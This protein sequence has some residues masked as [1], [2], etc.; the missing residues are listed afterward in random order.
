MGKFS[1]TTAIAYTNAPPHVGFALEL[2]QA[3]VLA[4]WH[5]LRGEKCFFLTGTDE[6]G[7]KVM[8]AAA[9]AGEDLQTFVDRLA[10]RFK[11]LASAL[12]ISND[13]FI[14]TSDRNRHWPGVRKLWK[15]LEEAGDLSRGT[16]RGLYCEGCEAFKKPSDLRDGRCPDHQTVPEVIEEENW[17]FR[18]SRYRD[19][20]RRIIESDEIRIV[21][22]ER[23]HEV[24][25]FLAQGLED[26]SFSR[27][28][29]DLPWGIPVP[30]DESQT[31]YVWADAL[32]NYLTGLGFGQGGEDARASL[33]HEF[34]PADVHV[35]GKDILRFHAIIWPAMLLS[36]KLPLPKTILVHG[37]ILS[38][39]TKM[40]K[41]LGN[42]ID[43]FAII[44]AY[45][46]D[47]LRYFLIREI[48]TTGDGDFTKERFH[49]VYHADLV[50]TLGNL[51]S[52]VTKL[53]EGRK[54][55]PQAGPD[56]EAV[57]RRAFDEYERALREYHLDVAIASAFRVASFANEFIER[58]KP[59]ALRTQRE[60][61]EELR[62][63]ILSQLGWMLGNLAW[64]LLPFLPETA[65]RIFERLGID[66][67]A[68]T[69]WEETAL[70]MVKGEAL[71]PRK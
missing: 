44:E 37:H 43:P 63:S 49:D 24:L 14:R 2:T 13:D 54:V 52:R 61:E 65:Q 58:T 71:F 46:A 4:R 3:D 66:P 59:W 35:I 36:A 33:F 26:V 42:V 25:A 32:A 8:K 10:D 47:A 39:G 6:H 55:K 23:K 21:P 11:E 40:A 1:I 9:D 5:R 12:R 56:V 28:R 57:V 16:Y 51:V 64:M 62:E 67:S 48:P 70:T 22:E 69:S 41:S 45:G 50:D 20:L 29:K 18:L 30:G 31:I 60:E 27:P 53:G 68:K 15:R 38:K 17:F 7:R 34:W 19:E